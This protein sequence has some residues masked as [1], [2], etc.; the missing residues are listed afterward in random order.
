M[1]ARRVEESAA[2]RREGYKGPAEY[3]AS[4]GGASVGEAR[5]QLATSSHLAARPTI[6][7]ALRRGALSSAQVGAVAEAAAADPGAERRLLQAATR[8]TLTE[9]R[10]E[11]A[12]VKAAAD[13]D[14]DATYRRIR[15]ARR[16]RAAGPTPKARGTW[17]P[18]ARSTTG[19]GSWPRWSR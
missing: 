9:L 7:D 11:C 12:R 14:P 8:L 5:R 4:K 17:P 16:L 6:A 10:Q 15:E 19:P 1:L 13:P 18:G 3:L 2:W